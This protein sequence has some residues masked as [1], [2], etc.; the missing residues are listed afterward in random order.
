MT[1]DAPRGLG[2]GGSGKRPVAEFVFGFPSSS[3]LP[4][5]QSSSSRSGSQSSASICS[6]RRVVSRDRIGRGRLG[7]ADRSKSSGTEGA[8]APPSMKRVASARQ[9]WAEWL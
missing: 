7:I 2:I 5:G 1:A 3:T 9:R 4:P 6:I 8:E